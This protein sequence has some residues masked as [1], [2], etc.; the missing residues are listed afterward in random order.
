MKKIY[1]ILLIS[2]ANFSYSQDSR[3]FDNYWYLTNFIEN[4]V[5]TT[6]SS[7]NYFY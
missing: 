4:G 1:L 2:L 6:T 7:I 5:T 3:L